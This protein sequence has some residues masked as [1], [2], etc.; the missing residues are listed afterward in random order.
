MESMNMLDQLKFIV[1]NTNERV[2]GQVLS[3]RK[4]KELLTWIMDE[5]IQLVDVTLKERV[6]FLLNGKPDVICDLGKKKTFNPVLKKYGFCDNI[7]RCSCF[8]QHLS[9][10]KKGMD[11]SNVV[12][13]RII[14]WKKK[15]GVD[16]VSKLESVQKK[17]KNTIKNN[18]QI[19]KI[20]KKL[21]HDKEST[22][23]EKIVERVKDSVVPLFSR[24]EYYGCRI[25]NKYSWK[26]VRCSNEFV[27]YVDSGRTPICKQCNPGVIR[28]GEVEIK[29][30]LLS[31]GI[32]NIIT[33]TKEVLGNLEYDIYLPDKK[34]AF[35]YNGVYWHS[36]LFKDSNYHVD[37]FI[38][39]R[40]AEVKLIQ[41][42][43]DEWLQ[44]QDIVKNRIKSVLGLNEKI[45]ARNCN[46]VELTNK[47]YKTFVEKN[48]L[49]GHANSSHRYG[50]KHNNVIVAVIGF[51]KSRYTSNGYELIRYCSEQTVVGGASKLF[52]H[53]V[54]KINPELVISYANR[55]W[56]DGNLYAKLGFKNETKDDRNTGYWYIKKDKRYHRSNFTKKRLVG[57][58]E[59]PNLTE[60]EIMKSNGFL[61]VYD[62]GNYRF[63]WRS[64]NK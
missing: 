44:K 1:D 5:S 9:A 39:S 46:L 42:F 54:A 45:Y 19:E 32:T 41:I 10:Q 16:N 8:K 64:G 36:D 23:F 63:I 56:S 53:F 18:C 11:L 60:A 51:G 35:E 17:R 40:D 43:E 31:L 22:G 50:L 12:E 33:N 47:E 20:Y 61:K 25:A 30:Y 24:D 62:C 21:A 38:K 2:L 15:Y 4:N 57:F 34:I 49:Q 59:D 6:W 55:C 27:D 14:T 26:C 7:S 58:G 48:H 52:K 13:K 28:T 37:K 29:N 3:S